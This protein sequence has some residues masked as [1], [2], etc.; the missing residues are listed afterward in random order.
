MSHKKD[1]I[2]KGLDLGLGE[3]IDPQPAAKE[4]AK[5]AKGRA[6]AK[7]REDIILTKENLLYQPLAL[8]VNGY[9]AT[10]FQQNVVIAVLRK[11]RGAIKDQ[12]DGQ[13][14]QKPVQLSI[15]DNEGVQKNFLR[16]GDLAFDIHLRE[17]GVDTPHYSQAFKAVCTIADAKVWV[18]ARKDD[19][20]EIMIR[21]SFFDIGSENVDIV[22]DPQTGRQTYKYKNRSPIFTVI[23]SKEVVNVLF[24]NDGRIYDFIDDTALMIA[25]KFPKRIYLYLSNFKYM[26]DGLTIDYWKFRHDIGFND[27]EVDAKTKQP[28]IQYPHYCD[29]VKRVLRPSEAT[30]R[31]MAEKNNSDFYFE[32][33]PIYKSGKRQKNPDQLHFD[34]HL[35]DVGQNIKDDKAA[36]RSTIE[37]EQRLQNDFDQSPAQIRRIVTSLTP[38]DRDPFIRKM[39][40]LQQLIEQK[41]VQIKDSKRSYCNRTF[42]DFLHTRLADKQQ[43]MAEQVAR[44]VAAH[45]QPASDTSTGDSAAAA[46]GTA[47]QG[48]LRQLYTE[49]DRQL[50]LQAKASVASQQGIE[51]WLPQI[52]L[53]KV[54]PDIVTIAV[55]THAFH[56][57]FTHFFGSALLDKVEELFAREVGIYFLQL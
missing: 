35:S 10:A 40:E 38:D 46:T 33:T 32:Y 3:P 53:Y 1:N 16:D 45:P 2:D 31:E 57:A 52:E 51:N 21:K 27:N 11:L 24:P 19:G 30:L 56:E 55:P 18:P 23:M 36:I 49:A 50:F 48:T 29:F 43:Q 20:T 37:I 8:A 15:F 17:L 6:K 34:F 14:R 54:E 41:K 5:K 22:I 7:K 39:D 25:E 9:E 44:S 13:F 26:P 47:T 4:A 42:T 12:R 28:V